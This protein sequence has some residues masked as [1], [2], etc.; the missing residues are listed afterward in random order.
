MRVIAS[1]ARTTRRCCAKSSSVERVRLCIDGLEVETAAGTTVM[2]AALEAGIHLPK[3][4][5]ADG[6]ESFGSC[7]V[8]LVEIEVFDNAAAY[9]AEALELAAGFIIQFYPTV[10]RIAAH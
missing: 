3:L 1:L 10:G 5:A 8:C 4:C 6:L 9:I 2:R 7:R